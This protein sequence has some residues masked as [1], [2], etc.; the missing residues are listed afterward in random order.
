[1][2]YNEC[3]KP[4]IK[5][6]L[7]LTVA[8]FT[9]RTLSA[10]TSKKMPYSQDRGTYVNSSASIHSIKKAFSDEVKRAIRANEFKLYYQPQIDI[11]T[12]EIVGAEALIRWE[13]PER[14]MLLPESFIP[15]AEYSGQIIDIERWT[16]SRLFRQQSEWQEQGR[17]LKNI[18]LNISGNHFLQG[19]LVT[20]TAHLLHSYQIDPGC[21][22]MELT[23]RITTDLEVWVS[24]VSML[25]DMG[26]KIS[27]DD[28]G[29]GFNTIAHLLDV[30][31]DFL[32]I[33]QS[34][35]EKM[36]QDNRAYKVVQ[37]L[38][39]MAD[40]LG[41]IPIAE[42][43]ESG[44]TLNLYKQTGGRIVQGHHYSAALPADVFLSK[45]L[46]YEK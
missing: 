14:G 18:A 13:H 1:M 4:V 16:L 12:G 40:I 21:I 38:V 28:F 39:N 32:K 46:T 26:V 3:N 6:V 45:Y 9:P 10:K 37:S 43:I 29:S 8:N 5:G 19:S 17:K 2:R 31:V 25:Q 35:M 44:E 11:N 15:Q 7:A 30:E 22:T 34:F 20:E 24:Q 27:I 42:G 23:E 33:D 36:V 41:A